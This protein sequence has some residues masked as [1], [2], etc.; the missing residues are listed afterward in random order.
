MIVF[1]AVLR[2]LTAKPP[3][4]MQLASRCMEASEFR[5]RKLRANSIC[6]REIGRI[7]GN[8]RK[9]IYAQKSAQIRKWRKLGFSP[10]RPTHPDFEPFGPRLEYVRPVAGGPDSVRYVSSPSTAT[11]WSRAFHSPQNLGSFGLC[12]SIDPD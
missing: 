6:A 2:L 3:A 12:A 4:R 8:E 9:T 7:W 10:R 1:T 5:A 11:P